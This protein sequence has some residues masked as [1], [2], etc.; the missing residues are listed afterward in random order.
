M[1]I[2]RRVSVPGNDAETDRYLFSEGT[3]ETL[4]RWLGAHPQGDGCV[5]RVWAPNAAAVSVVGDFNDWQSDRDA[6]H[7]LGESGVWEGSV[8]GARPGQRYKYDLKTRSGAS[9]PLKADP[10]AQRMQASP[11]TASEICP[12]E[13][14]QFDDD[15]WLAERGQ[16]M[17]SSAPIS[18]YEVHSA[19]WRRHDDGS[20]LSYAELG[21]NLIPYVKEM[22]F[23]HIQFLPM[24]EYPFDGSWGYQPVGLFAPTSRHGDPDG[25]RRLVDRCHQSGIGVLQDWVPGHF[26]S[27]PHGLVRFDGTALYEHEDPRK[28]FHQ[29]W[30]THIYNYG[31]REVDA[32][33][34]SNARFWIEEFHVDGLRVDA[35]ASMLYL[36]YSHE[37]DQW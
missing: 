26:P 36:D 10:L 28:G 12:E 16:R 5:F 11:E 17:A 14:Y 30:N 32:F 27:D 8:G 24:S 13:P 34:L 19:S 18:I 15:A 22:G 31:R 4:W 23:T 7:P 37:A 9:I 1:P 2:H 25:Y 6:L 20:Y 33:L 29:D 21:D 3:H 35:V